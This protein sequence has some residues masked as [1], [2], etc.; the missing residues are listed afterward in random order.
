MPAR[1]RVLPL[2]VLAIAA[3]LVAHDLDHLLN[4]ER[5]G[6]VG[7]A[8]WVVT[9]VQYA[10]LA[11]ILWLAASGGAVGRGAVAA[12]AVVVLLGF[13][14]AHAAPFGL[15]PYGELDAPALSWATV[16]APMLTAAAVLVA[17]RPRGGPAPASR[18]RP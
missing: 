5:L 14:V 4:Q 10:A 3:L 7:A 13:F 1:D 2:L 8:F 12:L 17:I 11:V 16:L 6:E 18:A 9:S 15:Q